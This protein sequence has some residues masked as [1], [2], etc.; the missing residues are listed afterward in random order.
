MFLHQSPAHET[1]QQAAQ[2]AGVQVE[3]P[4]EVDGRRLAPALDLEHHPRRAQG[5]VDV[6]QVE[7][8]DFLGE[9]SVES[10]N[11]RDLLP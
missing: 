10:A 7:H 3:G 2:V 5:E 11:S 9:E 8:T 1:A 6:H 4:G